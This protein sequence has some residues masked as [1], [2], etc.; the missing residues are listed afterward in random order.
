MRILHIG[1]YYPPY[2][3]GIENFNALVAKGAVR[4][5][6]E[7]TVLCHAGGNSASIEQLDGVEVI[8]S[9]VFGNWLYTPLAP[10]FLW[11]LWRALARVRPGVIH[12][13]LPN[14]SA[15]WLL[16]C[17]PAYRVPWILHWHADV[18]FDQQEKLGRFFYRV[19]YRPLEWLLLKRAASVVATSPNY[20]RSSKALRGFEAKSRVMSLSSE[21]RDEPTPAEIEWPEGSLKVLMVGRL[22]PYK[23]HGVLLNALWDLA[24]NGI[25]VSAIMVG[26]GKSEAELFS[27]A[28]CLFLE[29][30]ARILSDIDDETLA[31]LY[32]SCDLVC[33]PSLTRAEAFGMVLLEAM[34]HG[35]PV[36]A[37]K[38][39][40]SGVSWVVEDGETGWLFPVGDSGALAERLDWCRLHPEALAVAGQ[41]ARE[42]WRERFSEKEVLRQMMDCY[43]EAIDELG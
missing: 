24:E 10:F 9:R 25:D 43:A 5:G 3:G 31:S 18:E 26:G 35:K 17:L 16:I 29:K 34:S 14:V 19:V 38:L 15:F 37:S 8:R 28:Q 41:Y 27:A 39:V 13:H 23:G 22:T 42:R 7:V 32:A 11:D 12:V 4:E 6:A 20:L 36:V 30:R 33:L 21:T 1:K 40:D 2:R